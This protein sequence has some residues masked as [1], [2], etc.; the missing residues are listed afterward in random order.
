MLPVMCLLLNITVSYSS[1]DSAQS[2]DTSS[3]SRREMYVNEG[4]KQQL[5]EA[6]AQQK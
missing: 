2:N 3:K 6:K 1:S 4:R 5:K